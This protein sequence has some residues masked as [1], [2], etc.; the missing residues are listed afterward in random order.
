VSTRIKP[1]LYIGLQLRITV[2][3]RALEYFSGILFLTTNRVTTF[4]PAVL[5]R[6][7]LVIEYKFPNG[8]MKKK[9]SK[10]A[11]A[12][13]NERFQLDSK[14]LA[15]Y[16]AMDDSGIVA[17]LNPQDATVEGGKSGTTQKRLVP[18][19]WSGREI[20]SGMYIHKEAR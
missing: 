8:D 3:L 10:N 7:V 6:M 1:R 4:D 17:D 14:A 2:F 12:K 20:V 15:S 11:I 16:E 5:D 18:Y 13:L 19:D 9:I